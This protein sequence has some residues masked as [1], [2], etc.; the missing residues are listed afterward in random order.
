MLS[1][2]LNAVVVQRVE[3]APGLLVLRVAPVG[4]ELAPFKPGQFAVLGLPPEAPRHPFADGDDDPIPKPGTLIRRSYSIA[5]SSDGRQYL[6]FY[7]T[8]VRSGSLTPRLF[9]LGVGDRLWLGPKLTGVF[10]F[11]RAPADANLVM[12]ATG[13]GLAP[14][15]SQLR[16]DLRA[17]SA[18][19]IAVLH[20]A[21]HS[22]DLGYRDEL[23]AMQRLSSSLTYI[24]TV[25][26]PDQEPVPW[27]GET[28]Y[29]QELW[30]RHRLDDAWGFRP[31]PE[32]T[33]VFLCGNPDMVDSMTGL[34]AAEG[35]REHTRSQPGQVHSERFW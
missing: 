16:S 22:W 27:G 4:W 5:S 26:R 29:V 3:V 28:G 10:T 34:L 19:R 1:S 15:M 11:D 32:N 20:G 8:L 23:I 7:L 9:A 2:E 18:R 13:T 35:F 12:V 30:T 21:R 6:E 14:Y 25:S 17:G 24:A 31:V 33:H